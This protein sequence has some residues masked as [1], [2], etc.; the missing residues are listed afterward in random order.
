MTLTALRWARL[1][2]LASIAVW[3]VALVYGWS[4][5][6]EYGLFWVIG[7]ITNFFIIVS[8]VVCVVIQLV[9]WFASKRRD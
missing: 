2:L 1:I 3:L 4:R 9:F 8:A 6:A 5:P 7:L